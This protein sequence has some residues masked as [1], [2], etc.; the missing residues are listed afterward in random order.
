MDVL[1]SLIIK[2][3][4]CLIHASDIYKN[5]HSKVPN[6]LFPYLHFGL[7]ITTFHCNIALCHSVCDVLKLC[8]IAICVAS[9]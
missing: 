8:T 5:A 9:W 6:D 1:R 2:E 7:Q 4:N 3:F